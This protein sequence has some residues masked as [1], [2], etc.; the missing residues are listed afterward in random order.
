[1]AAALDTLGRLTPRKGGRESS[2]GGSGSDL[3]QQWLA[4]LA[5]AELVVPHLSISGG[6]AA[7]AMAGPRRRRNGG[8]SPEPAP[9]NRR[10][11]G[12]EPGGRR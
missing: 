11:N 1:V 8:G 10:P 6:Q 7:P 2:A 3:T 5:W 9:L 4:R 12:P